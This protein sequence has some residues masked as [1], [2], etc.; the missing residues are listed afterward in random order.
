M[1][2]LRNAEAMLRKVVETPPQL[3]LM[4]WPARSVPVNEVNPLGRSNAAGPFPVTAT[5]PAV[6]AM[7]PP[8][9]V[10]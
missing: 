10:D 9:T 5:E 8:T 7:R 2:S 3:S 4:D 6:A 1:P